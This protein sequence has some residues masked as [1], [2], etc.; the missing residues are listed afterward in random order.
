MDL[1]GIVNIVHGSSQLL[2]SAEDLTTGQRVAIKK[3]ANPFEK[4]TNAKRLLRE[5]KLQSFFQHENVLSILD[6][7]QPPTKGEYNDVY[8]VS[9][10]MDTDLSR[11]I[12]SG[13][14]LND[15]HFQWFLYQALVGLKYIHSAKII[16][17]DLVRIISPHI[18]DVPETQ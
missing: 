14:K 1:F 10:L 8:I 3:I 17:R 11:I 18:S 15:E 6:I 5:I 9:K 12:N 13:E 7:M 2:S 16:H 4:L